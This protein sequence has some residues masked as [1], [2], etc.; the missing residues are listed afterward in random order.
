MQM[1][2]HVYKDVRSNVKVRLLE[3]GGEFSGLAESLLRG[4]PVKPK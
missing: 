2:A 1:S 3:T 4:W